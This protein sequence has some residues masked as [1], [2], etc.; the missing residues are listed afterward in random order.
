MNAATKFYPT[1]VGVSKE[2]IIGMIDDRV[3][4]QV[5]PAGNWG[6]F[7]KAQKA[8]AFSDEKMQAF[9]NAHFAPIVAATD[10]EYPDMEMAREKQEVILKALK[11]QLEQ[12]LAK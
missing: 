1:I 2:D 6:H 10:E 9:V 3:T 7:N 11:D 5:W 12:E 4:D 8:A